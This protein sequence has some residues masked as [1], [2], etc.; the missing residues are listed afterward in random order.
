MKDFDWSFS[1]NTIFTNAAAMQVDSEFRPVF[2]SFAG[3]DRGD[4]SVST[5][6]LGDTDVY[7]T[8]RILNG[9]LDIGAVEYDWRPAFAAA[10]GRRFTMTYAS[11]SVT[12][13]ATGGLRVPGGE[14]VGVVDEKGA[15]YI[16]F[17]LTGGTLAVYVGE[18]LVGE[19]SGAGEQKMRFEVDDAES[20]IRFV[21]T[22]EAEGSD[23]AVLAKLSSG[24]GFVLMYR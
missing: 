10:L 12:M 1:H 5:E 14:I 17:S 11:P 16:A 8:P 6:A 9:A 15:Y 7:G 24:R 18:Q 3:I 21:F 2:G 4:N 19:S 23:T 13:N 20:K 22:P